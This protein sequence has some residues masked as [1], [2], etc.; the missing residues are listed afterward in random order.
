MRRTVYV[1][2]RGGSMMASLLIGA[3]RPTP[4]VPAP[5]PAS[6]SAPSSPN[7]SGPWDISFGQSVSYKVVINA[8]L[9][10]RYI[11]S[12]LP[13]KPLVD[14]SSN[15]ATISWSNPTATRWNG[16]LTSFGTS[17]RTDPVVA[18]GDV[19]FPIPLTFS[20]RTPVGPWV[21]TAPSE[22]ACSVESAVAAIGREV[23]IPVPAQLRR[24]SSWHD[25]STVTACRD[26][27]PL[28]V[29][30]VR[31]Y[32]VVEAVA[33]GDAVQLRIERITT[34]RIHGTGRQLG[35]PVTITG[36]GSGMMR[37]TLARTDGFIVTGEGEQTLALRLE[38]RRRT[39]EVRQTT[40]LNVQRLPERP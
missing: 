22:S 40:R 18:V 1:L 2:V 12:V 28:E 3:C 33:V 20:A 7:L 17:V 13:S 31:R 15:V 6:P 21:R 26:S 14:S 4:V 32:R 24:D 29:T 10:S 9:M 38:G 23:V 36:S 37:F 11:D 8:A 35:E 25:S 39:Q 30:S 5:Q 19:R 34:T 16:Q 27:I